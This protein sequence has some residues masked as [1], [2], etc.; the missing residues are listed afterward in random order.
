MIRGALM[1][2]WFAVSVG[3]VI[4]TSLT[5]VRPHPA[6]TFPPS[7][8]GRCA[9]AGC[10]SRSAPPAAPTPAIKQTVRLPV[11]HSDANVRVAGM[12]VEYELMPGQ[13][14]G[15]IAVIVV[16]S[17][18]PLGDWELSFTLPGASIDHVM[19]ARWHRQGEDGVVVTGS[20]LPWRGESRDHEARIVVIGTGRPARPASCMLDGASCTFRPMPR[21]YGNRQDF[22]QSGVKDLDGSQR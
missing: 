16:K 21:H 14:D 1:T 3:I 12:E 9:V 11:Q 7:K 8:T 15:F 6:L 5:L 2:P 18:K 17:R 19:W 10:S 20:P 13:S 22:F 4:A